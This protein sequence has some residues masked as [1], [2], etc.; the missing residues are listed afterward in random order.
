M[1]SSYAGHIDNTH[2][3]YND[4]HFWA[5]PQSPNTINILPFVVQ[6][7]TKSFVY[8]CKNIF[9]IFLY[10]KC[11]STFIDYFLFTFSR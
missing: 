11:L 8:F 10:C 6:N 9:H 5:T 3:H 7:T 1:R 4:D 2:H